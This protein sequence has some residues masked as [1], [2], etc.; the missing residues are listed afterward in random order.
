MLE[1]GQLAA[2]KVIEARTD[3]PVGA[4]IRRAIDAY[5][6]TQTVIPKAEMRRILASGK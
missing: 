2:L 1:P 6:E 4:L 3:A 5:L